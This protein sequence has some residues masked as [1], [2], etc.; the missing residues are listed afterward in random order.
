M[1]QVIQYSSMLV[2]EADGRS[3]QSPENVDEICKELE[4][5]N[6]AQEHMFVLT[7]NTKNKLI[8]KHLISLG[9][10]NSS[11]VHPREVFRPAIADGASSII[12]V[13]NHPSGDP[14]P[15]SNDIAITK[16]IIEGGK[17]L[18]IN[19]LDHVIVGKTNLSLRECGLCSFNG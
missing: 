10:V 15:S 7:L 16:K 18:E 1:Y 12:L 9:T 13:H 3:I 6:K 19:V 8:A 4:L 17:L 2:K 14:S 5:H 11:L